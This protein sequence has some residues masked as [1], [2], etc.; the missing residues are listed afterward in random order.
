MR[1]HLPVI[2]AVLSLPAGLAA[3]L[4]TGM[5][6][7]SVAPSIA[8]SVVGLFAPL[9]VAGL[10]MIPFVAPWFDRRAKTDLARIQADREQREEREDREK[11]EAGG[12]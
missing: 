8:M 4:V 12:Q 5:V 1:R 10:V 9:F 11:R 3:Y 2:L 6:L 7:A